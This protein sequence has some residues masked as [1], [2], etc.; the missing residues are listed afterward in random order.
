MKTTLLF[1]S[2]TFFALFSLNISAQESFAN[3]HRTDYY[4]GTETLAE[5]EMRVVALGTGNP[6]PRKSQAST[7]WFVELGNGDKFFFDIGTGSQMNFPPLRVSYR[8]ADKVFLSHLH[9]DHAGDL[10]EI[11]IGGWLAGRWDRPL[12]IW[13]PSGA[14]PEMGTAHFLKMQK[15]AWTWDLASRHGKLPAAGA[16][17]E[18]H[19]FDYSKTQTVYQ[20]NGVTISSFPALHG[21]D[22][23]V[24]YRLDWNELSFVFSGDTTQTKFMLEN[25]RNVDLLLHESIDTV[26]RM[27]DVWGWDEKLA[28]IV[29]SLIHTQP[30][31][32]GRMFSL[33][34]PRMA[35]AFHF[36]YDLQSVPLVYDDI[37][38]TYSGPLVLARDGVVF[39]VT[40]DDI[41]VCMVVANDE[42]YPETV[43]FDAYRRAGR[44]ENTRASQWLLD[45]RLKSE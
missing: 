38:S 36:F 11:W 35:V 23:P 5:D 21:P 19:E 29:G 41:R 3:Y 40:P 6:S 2:S 14:T 15:A 42:T 24:S 25:A 9:S 39:N 32:A 31:A 1:A 13:G 28:N 16:E 27:I 4:P 7:S 30:A 44:S 10:A 8:D 20:Q 34:K 37:R 26:Q 43:D 12:R 17:L 18:I 33:V 45:S 22:G